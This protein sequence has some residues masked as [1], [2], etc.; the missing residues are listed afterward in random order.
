MNATF[1]TRA[2]VR[3]RGVCRGAERCCCIR[4]GLR[5]GRGCWRGGVVILLFV[6]MLLLLT[7]RRILQTFQV[8]QHLKPEGSTGRRLFHDNTAVTGLHRHHQILFS[9][10]KLALKTVLTCQVF[11]KVDLST[12]EGNDDCSSAADSFLRLLCASSQSFFSRPRNK[13]ND[14]GRWFVIIPRGQP[15][16]H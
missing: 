2:L 5:R 15:V 16:G 6:L 1:E 13:T 10:A 14:D 9:A 8:L 11:I 4:G 3:G 12:R 7:S